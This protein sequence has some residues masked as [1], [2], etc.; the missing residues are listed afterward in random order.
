LKKREVYLYTV[1]GCTIGVDQL[2][3]LKRSK[4]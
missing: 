2:T 3:C 1:I 4:L